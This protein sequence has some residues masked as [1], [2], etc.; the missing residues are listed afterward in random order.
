MTPETQTEDVVATGIDFVR[1]IT[2][3][4]GT[5]KGLELWEKIASVVD[6]DIKGQ[7]F[8]KMLTGDFVKKVTVTALDPNLAFNLGNVRQINAVSCIKTIRDVSNPTLSLKDAK[9]AYDR[10]TD[11][12]ETVI[13]IGKNSR[14]D[15]LKKLAMVGINA[16]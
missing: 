5:E 8:F 15:V 6:P 13:N 12:K 3:L 7:I 1:A 4:Y 10:L 11:G 16:H 14:N 2:T 9:D